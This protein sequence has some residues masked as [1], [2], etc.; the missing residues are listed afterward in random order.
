MNPNQHFF[1]A[2]FGPQ[3]AQIQQQIPEYITHNEI[4]LEIINNW[5]CVKE[6]ISKI[7][8]GKTNKVDQIEQTWITFITQK[9]Y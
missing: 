7:K 4:V 6:L 1:Q 9:K 2:F 8:S 3:Q 5:D